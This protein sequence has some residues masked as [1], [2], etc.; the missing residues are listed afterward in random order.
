MDRLLE[1]LGFQGD[2][3][4][5][6]DA[7]REP[8]LA[9][10]FVPPPYFA[11]VMGDTTQ[12]TPAVVF[13]PRGSG[14]SAQRRMIEEE[15]MAAASPTFLCVTYDEFDQPDGFT[16]RAATW[17]YHAEHIIRGILLR[18]LVA[19]DEEPWRADYLASTDKQILSAAIGEYLESATAEQ[20]RLA[21]RAVKSMAD[22]AQSFWNKYSGPVGLVVNALLVSQK[23]PPIPVGTSAI[24]TTPGSSNRRLL[25]QQLARIAKLM[26]FNSV[27]IVVDRVDELS[28]T[29]NSAPNSFNLIESLLLD[30]STLEID[31]L[32]FKFFLWDQLERA[33][34]ISGARPDRVRS[35]SLHWRPDEL[36]QMLSKRLGAYSDGRITSFNE[37]TLDS[38]PF[39]MNKLVS[40][41][42]AGSPRDVVR[43][44]GR[45]VAE[46][47]RIH[48][49]SD[50]ISYESVRRGVWE[51][52]RERAQE[53]C[54]LNEISRAGT[55]QFTINQLASD[56][57]KINRQGMQSRVDAWCDS[58]V[59]AK[60]GTQAT[61]RTGRPRD[62]YAITDVRVGIATRPFEEVTILLEA[63]VV[64]CP[65][66]GE[67][68]LAEDERVICAR[69]G[70]ENDFRS[71]GSLYTAR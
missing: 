42:G 61:S 5:Y 67:A 59:V 31:G 7:D 58:G 62:L 11:A 66:C 3:F 46:H 33:Y 12:P 6:T 68:T 37:L 14:K 1:S 13:A 27:Y 69:C 4:E 43:L 60:V 54:D 41:L 56:V 35:Y 71:C 26:Q 9:D 17:N 38:V 18:I 50:L 20:Y 29:S 25:L 40:R 64:L 39:D 51:Y 65:S 28:S 15:A 70:A 32:G 55:F 57:F 45:I 19:V 48:Q 47:G 24:T 8:R 10:Y 52:C 23:L 49:S 53:L 16:V 22:R 34:R 63:G 21:Q 30:L 2:P 44:A 36:E